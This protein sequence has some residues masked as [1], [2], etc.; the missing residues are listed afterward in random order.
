MGI[1]SRL[2]RT[3]AAFRT[4]RT[5]ETARQ[6][7]APKT[8]RSMRAH[9]PARTT[10][11]NDYDDGNPAG[12]NDIPPGLI[13]AGTAGRNH[14]SPVLT[15]LRA[16]SGENTEDGTYEDFLNRPSVRKA[17]RDDARLRGYPPMDRDA[18]LELANRLRTI[19]G[20]RLR[21]ICGGRDDMDPFAAN[22][23]MFETP[24]SRYDGTYLWVGTDGDIHR[25]YQERGRIN[26]V[27]SIDDED[28]LAYD[29]VTTIVQTRAYRI[30]TAGPHEPWTDREWPMRLSAL[31]EALMSCFGDK[32]RNRFAEENERL[33]RHR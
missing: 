21:E 2:I 15:V 25:T 29:L 14:E 8:S 16:H 10:R 6:V 26:P 22:Q 31:Q 32:W 23:M 7:R 28:D 4:M 3:F 11:P 20:K 17:I 18:T 1:L 30:M 5:S 12:Q 33:L 27:E 13:D 24:W 9:G 19:Y